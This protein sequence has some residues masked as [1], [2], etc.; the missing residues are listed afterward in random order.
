ME[1]NVCFYQKKQ[2]LNLMIKKKENI[3]SYLPKQFC[4][5]YSDSESELELESELL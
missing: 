4:L 1:Q 5:L 2:E 3:G